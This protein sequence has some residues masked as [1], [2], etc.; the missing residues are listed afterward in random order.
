MLF[1]LFGMEYAAGRSLRLSGKCDSGRAYPESPE[2]P[3]N[4]LDRSFYC[5][6]DM[7]TR[8]SDW[9]I[10]RAGRLGLDRA[11]N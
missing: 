3:S 10:A 8:V 1:V 6:C 9:G 4:D 5:N 7:M 11:L 2:A